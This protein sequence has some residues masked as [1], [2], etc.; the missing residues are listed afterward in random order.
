MNGN[1][2]G[3]LLLLLVGVMLLFMFVTGRL[4]WL[5]S[6]ARDVNNARTDGFRPGPPAATTAAQSPST[7]LPRGM[8]A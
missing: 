5:F 4:E 1:S 3:P 8:S 7:P 2:A 6:L